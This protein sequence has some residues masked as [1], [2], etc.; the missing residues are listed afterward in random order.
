MKG[1]LFYS[2]ATLAG[3]WAVDQAVNVSQGGSFGGGNGPLW[4]KIFSN[5]STINYYFPELWLVV[6][7]LV[8]ILLGIFL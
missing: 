1:I 7:G 4:G 2:G 6:V 5:P 8:L 3:V